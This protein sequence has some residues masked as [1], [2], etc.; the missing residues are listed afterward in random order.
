[1]LVNCIAYKN[2]SRIADLPADEIS[3]YLQRGDCFVW[4]ALR[5]ASGAELEQM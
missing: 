2:G 4:V 5:D 1:M 3:D